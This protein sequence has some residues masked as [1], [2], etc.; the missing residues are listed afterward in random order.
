MPELPEVETVRKGLEKKLRNFTIHEVEILRQ[1]S[2]AYPLDNNQFK[3]GL[4][5]SLIEKWNRRGKY[6]IDDLKKFNN[7]NGFLVIHLRMTG[8]F[9]WFEKKKYTMQAY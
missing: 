2:I 7:N 3:N 6:L 4:K 9:K 8:Y 5:S 1:S